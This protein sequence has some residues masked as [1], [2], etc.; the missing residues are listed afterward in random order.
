MYMYMYLSLSLY[1]YI[2][3]YSPECQNARE[4]G[5]AAL[6]RSLRERGSAP[7]GVGTLRL[8]LKSSVKTLLVKCPSVQW[9]PDGLTIHTNKW[10]L[11]AGFLGAAPIFL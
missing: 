8:F 2:Y 1:I 10:F 3:I 4:A 7:K 11:G 5:G 9:Q 6:G